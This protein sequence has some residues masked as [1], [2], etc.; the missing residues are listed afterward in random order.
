MAKTVTSFA[1]RCARESM[2]KDFEV[3]RMS[4]SQQTLLQFSSN[5]PEGLPEFSSVTAVYAIISY[6]LSV[7]ISPAVIEHDL[8]V[9][10]V[11]I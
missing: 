2:R 4:S 11:E 10:D 1:F 3:D 8:E 6:V 5:P 9:F 7:K